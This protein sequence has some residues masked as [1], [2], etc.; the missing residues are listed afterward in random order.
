M[1]R[2]HAGRIVPVAPSRKAAQVEAEEPG[3]NRGEGQIERD[4]GL[5][6]VRVLADLAGHPR[7][8]QAKRAAT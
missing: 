7:F 1:V 2:E 5:V 3:R 4:V 6:E 8:V